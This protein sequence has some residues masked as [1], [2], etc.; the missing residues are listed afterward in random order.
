MVNVH[1]IVLYNIDNNSSYPH[2][3]LFLKGVIENC[4]V[5][6]NLKSITSC[7]TH[8]KETQIYPVECINSSIKSLIELQIG[9]N[10]IKISCACSS[11]KIVVEYSPR[12]T[13]FTVQP[14][15]IV[16]N[17]SD[18]RFQSPPNENNSAESACKR[19]TLGCK[20][21][22]LIFAELLEMVGH[23]RKTFELSSAGCCV[24]NSNLTYQEARKTNQEQLWQYFAKEIMNSSIGSSKTKYL[25][26]LSCTY[27]NK[28]KGFVSNNIFDAAEGYVA[29]G[30]GGLALL[31]SACLYTWPEYV[32]NVL[33]RFKDESVVNKSQFLD[34]S[35]YRGTIAGCYSTTLG[36]ALHELCHTLDLGHTR[37]GI[38]GR[39]FNNI[40]DFFIK[41]DYDK[42]R[43]M[44][45]FYIDLSEFDFNWT[46][47]CLS[48]L[49]YHKWLNSFKN[50]SLGINF[51]SSMHLLRSL[52]GIR[53]VELRSKEKELV[54]KHWIFDKKVLKYQFQIPIEELSGSDV[55]EVTIFCI[56]NAGET[57]KVSHKLN[58]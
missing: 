45:K 28:D 25:A 30:G 56:D 54:I 3:L 9:K 23:S 43:E 10:Y 1:R 49:N 5:K 26:F 14:L 11:A 32:S 52:A 13:D 36:S 12:V 53:V 48:I 35:C 24:F 47:N 55:N 16:C 8:D 4:G 42:N 6:C 39:G 27:F 31:G 29:F 37:T 58:C 40:Q 20:I 44:G 34:D 46:A 38:M 21:L 15:Y 50:I 41:D 57:L 22:Q 19:I 51:N 7:V 18:G 17:G 2:S 33:D